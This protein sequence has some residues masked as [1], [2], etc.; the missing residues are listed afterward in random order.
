MFFGDDLDLIGNYF[1][2][3]RQTYKKK[4]YL[5][6]PVFANFNLIPRMESFSVVNLRVEENIFAK[7][8][9]KL[10]C[11]RSKQSPFFKCGS[12]GVTTMDRKVKIYQDIKFIIALLPY[13]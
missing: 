11:S 13:V 3:R 6:E 1:H 5:R 9:V 10:T 7:A 4:N 12:G 2:L 8:M